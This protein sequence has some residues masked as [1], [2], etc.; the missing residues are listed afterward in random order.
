MTHDI[1]PISPPESI[2]MRSLCDSLN[3]TG[4]AAG[5]LSMALSFTSRYTEEMAAALMGP[6]EPGGKQV[7]RAAKKPPYKVRRRRSR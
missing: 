3:A 5:K 2:A 1:K 6:I 7:S 4:I